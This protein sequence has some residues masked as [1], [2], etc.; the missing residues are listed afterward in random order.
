MSLGRL[1]LA[2]L[3]ATALVWIELPLFG[4]SFAV[5]EGYRDLARRPGTMLIPNAYKGVMGHPE[6][7]SDA[8]HPNGRGYQAL[9]RRVHRAIKPY[10]H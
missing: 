2:V 3:A 9:A 6:L 5:A 7:M 1:V 8:V 10:L 4:R